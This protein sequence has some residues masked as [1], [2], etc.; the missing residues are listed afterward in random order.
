MRRDAAVVAA[1]RPA[2]PARA[3]RRLR[4]RRAGRRS[5]APRRACRRD[6][7]LADAGRSWRASGSRD[8]LGSGSIDFRVGDM[9]DPALGELRPRRRDG[10]AD[11]LR[12]ARHGCACWRG[13]RRARAQSMV[14]TF[15]PRTPFLTV[16]HAVGQAVPARRPRRRR[17]NRSRERR[18]RRRTGRR[19]REFADWQRGRN[20][21]VVSS[22][23]ISQAM[24]LRPLHDARAAASASQPPGRR[25]GTRFLPFAD[26]AT[27][28]AAACAPAAAVA[29]PGVRRHG[30]GAAGRHAE[31]RD[32]RRARRAG[33]A[34]GA[35]GRAAAAWSRRSAR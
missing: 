3:R 2:R 19:C 17:S 10:L 28:G 33:L 7:P 14:F 29:V 1:G 4:H 16:M 20:Q 11:P 31:P 15:A 21:R 32:D 27:R 12:H 35:D 18:L 23:Y 9:L 24:E 6:R 13:W 8:L 34:G 25:I 30:D 26:A 22:F 5:R